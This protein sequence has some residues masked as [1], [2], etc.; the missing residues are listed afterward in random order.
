ME[1]LSPALEFSDRML[2]RFMVDVRLV[3]QN[4]RQPALFWWLDG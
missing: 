3:A 4:L 2:L 1:I